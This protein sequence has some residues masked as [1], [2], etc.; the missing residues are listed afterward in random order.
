MWADDVRTD[1]Y[2]RTLDA[3]ISA[4]PDGVRPRS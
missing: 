1:D 2:R 3:I 4:V